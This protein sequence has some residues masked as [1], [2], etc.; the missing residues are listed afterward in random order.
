[1]I[2]KKSRISS[3]IHVINLLAFRFYRAENYTAVL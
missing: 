3:R 2:G 1:V